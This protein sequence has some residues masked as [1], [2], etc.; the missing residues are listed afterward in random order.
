MTSPR[1]PRATTPSGRPS[2]R[3]GIDFGGTKIEG[4]VLDS[5]GSILCRKR[6]PTETEK[7]YERI[8]ENVKTVYDALVDSID[9]R[10]HTLGMGAP[11]ASGPDGIH[12]TANP[13]CLNGKTWHADLEALLGHGL[14][15]QN[16]ATCFAMAEARHGAGR[17]YELVFGATLGT[18]CGG[19]IVYKGEVIAGRQSRAGEW[20][21]MT[22]DPAGPVC[23]CG[24]RG[25]AQAMISG[26]ALERRYREEFGI[27]RTLPEIQVEYA[28][29]DE[30]TVAFMSQFFRDFGTAMANVVAVLDPDVIVLGGGV[31]NIDGLYSEGAREMASRLVP[32]A[33]PPPIV[34]NQ[35]GDT[36]GAIGAALVGRL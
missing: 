5:T 25:C 9:G 28:R 4:I 26:K 16:D 36:A 2:L 8:C 3:V 15:I 27:G 12:R 11:G 33:T 29:A 23:M 7:G 13:E 32:H 19:G 20:G 14:V 30:R 18:G 34:R 35:L 10:P 6:V 17:G 22:L 1:L 31:S 24:R 21:H